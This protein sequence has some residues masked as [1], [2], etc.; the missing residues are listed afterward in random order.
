MGSKGHFRNVTLFVRSSAMERKMQRRCRETK[1]KKKRPVKAA[2][3]AKMTDKFS[4]S[5]PSSTPVTDDSGGG[6]DGSDS[7]THSE[8]EHVV[9]PEV[10]WT[11]FRT[12]RLCNE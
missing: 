11:A 7:G 3:C 10:S 9:E 5:G 1:Q 6:G 8:Q 4:T 2:K 12:F